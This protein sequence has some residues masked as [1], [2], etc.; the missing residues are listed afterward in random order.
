MY[1]KVV[2]Y[3]VQDTDASSS[4][5]INFMECNVI[6]NSAVV[7]GGGIAF[8]VGVVFHD[9]IM[10]RK[11]SSINSAFLKFM[12]NQLGV[13]NAHFPRLFLSCGTP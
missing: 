1:T 6:K 4:A 2:F 8:G 10:Q 7:N 5:I 9:Q 12:P 13:L 11:L 3:F